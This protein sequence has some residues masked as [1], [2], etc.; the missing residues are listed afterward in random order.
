MRGNRK[1]LLIIILFLLSIICVSVETVKSQQYYDEIGYTDQHYVTATDSFFNS[2]IGDDYFTYVTT[3]SNPQFVPLVEDLDND[4]NPEII[5]LDGSTV[6]VY[7]NKELNI[8]ASITNSNISTYGYMTTY[9]IDGDSLK[10]IIIASSNASDISILSYNLGSLTQQTAFSIGEHHK[11]GEVLIGCQDTNDCLAVY[12]QE[13]DAYTGA[14]LYANP[15]NSSETLGETKLYNH[16][17][18]DAGLI[19]FPHIKHMTVQDYDK[20]GT[21]EY[22]FSVQ[23]FGQAPVDES[24]YIEYLNVVGSTVTEEQV[25]IFNEGDF[26]ESEIPHDFD[27]VAQNEACDDSTGT[28]RAIGRSFTAPYVSDVVSTGS[29]ETAIA[30]MIGT[31]EYRMKLF[32]ASGVAINTYPENFLGGTV[33]GDGHIL[34]NIFKASIFEANSND[35]CVMGYKDEGGAYDGNIDSLDMVCASEDTTVFTSLFG[36]VD[37]SSDEF[38]NNNTNLPFNLTIEYNNFD[39]IVNTGEFSGDDGVSEIATSYGIMS[40]DYGSIV[41]GGSEINIIFYVPHEEGI[42]IP[43]DI[44]NSSYSDLLYMT[45]TNLFLYDDLWVNSPLSYFD[46][47]FSPCNDGTWK[48]NT[49]FGATITPYDIDGDLVSARVILYE[50]DENQQDTGWSNNLSSGTSIPLGADLKINKTTNNGNLVLQ[51]R[52][53]ENLD[54]VRELEFTFSV[55][56]QGLEF[57]DCTATGSTTV[58]GVE[59]D[60]EA[61]FNATSVN[62]QSNAVATGMETLSDSFGGIGASTVY[63]IIM[64]IVMIAI[65]FQAGHKSP[66]MALG[67]IA[68]V[69]IMFSYIGVKLQILG[70][71]FI[72]IL[73]IAMLLATALWASRFITSA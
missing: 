55:G 54:V 56:N 53:I 66:S 48:I 60:E 23:N 69:L 22:I 10:E 24:M 35:F 40:V 2:A 51:A 5:I 39:F 71:G 52:D 44:E 47:E 27:E 64:F 59:E 8:N 25:I 28:Y 30:Y 73:V 38:H 18:D 41:W 14:S 6:K 34:S 17:G 33:N 7:H 4:R 13:I 31:D 67:I 49:S 37:V 1:P 65:W 70:I 50:G 9:D 32:D 21:K 15:F 16:S 3:L 11:N 26:Y 61:S 20:D 45:T 36:L 19:C 68:I 62:Y 43:V 63:L 58:Y 29:L 72:L 12:T 57:G 46:Y 42:L